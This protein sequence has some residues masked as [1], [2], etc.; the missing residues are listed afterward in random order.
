MYKRQVNNFGCPTPTGL[1]SFWSMEFETF[2][3]DMANQFEPGKF[4]VMK[5]IMPNYEPPASSAQGGQIDLE[6]YPIILTTGRR[7]PVYFHSEHRQLPWCR[8]LWPAPRL[9][10]NPADA[11]KLGLKQGDWAWIETA[12][13]KVRQCVD[14][15]HGIAPGWA[16][17]EHAWWFPELPA[18][19]HGCL[20]SN[21][22][23]I[24]DPEGQDKFISSHH[25]R[26]VPVKIYKATPENCPDG[27]VIPCAPE[28]GTQIICDASDPRLKEWLPNYD[29]RE[30]A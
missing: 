24:W 15:Y 27:K 5:E 3:L 30:E 26:G 23:C 29:I 13:G 14:L 9:E 7:I 17:A 11:E 28:D 20:L 18:P 6:E 25:M 21:I 22:E 19:T 8:E 2:C 10:L 1:V 12:W 16:N 4:D